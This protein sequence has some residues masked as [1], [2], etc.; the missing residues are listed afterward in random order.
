MH[1]PPRPRTLRPALR[2]EQRVVAD[3]GEIGGDHRVDVTQRVLR[4]AEQLRGAADAVRL[5]KRARAGRRR[6]REQG[7]H[8][9]ADVGG[10]GVAVGGEQS[11]VEEAGVAAEQ[12]GQQAGQFGERAQ[13]GADGVVGEGQGGGGDGGAVDEGEGVPAVEGEG[14]QSG[15]GEGVGGGHAVAVHVGVAPAAQCLGGV[16]EG[17]QVAAGADGAV[18]G[19]GGG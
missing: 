2:D 18:P 19:H 3:A 9:G 15:G 1:R 7:A 16:G 14:A 5:L 10:P 17:D 13:G 8:A 6:P 11:G 4:R 12:V